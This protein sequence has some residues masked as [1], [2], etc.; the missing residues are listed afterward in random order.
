MSLTG[1]IGK[2]AMFCETLITNL[3][4]LKLVF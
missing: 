1:E 4:L 3:I 2:D